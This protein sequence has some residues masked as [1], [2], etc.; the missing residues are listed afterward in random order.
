MNK[1]DLEYYCRIC[2]NGLKVKDKFW[3]EIK[4]RFLEL[5]L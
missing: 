5:N 1:E 4:L 2:Y 3:E